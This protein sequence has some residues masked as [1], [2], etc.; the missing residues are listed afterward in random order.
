M[1]WV[2]PF[3]PSK[4]PLRVWGSR[5]PSNTCFL[6]PTQ[7]HIPNGIWIGSAIFAQLMAV[8]QCT[9]ILQ[10]AA[11]FPPQNCPFTWG[12]LDSRLI[13]GSLDPP[14]S[15]SWIASQSVH[16]LLQGSRSWPRDGQTDRPYY[17]VCSNSLHPA[18]AAMQP[19]KMLCYLRINECVWTVVRD[20]SIS[21][22]N[23]GICSSS[24]SK[25]FS[26]CSKLLC[27]RLACS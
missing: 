6:W 25:S 16:S 5:P 15:T 17:C 11:T 12:N 27:F 22:S 20:A 9:Y 14:E 21:P 13:H 23:S 26:H 3:L 1:S 24:H 18:S 8:C 2:G 7:V 10:Y 19:N 4:L